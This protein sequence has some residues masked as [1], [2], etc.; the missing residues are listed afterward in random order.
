M[1]L[2]NVTLFTG[3]SLWHDEFMWEQICQLRLSCEMH[4][5]CAMTRSVSM[6]YTIV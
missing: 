6:L 1:Q 4:S 2:A 3:F 5:I